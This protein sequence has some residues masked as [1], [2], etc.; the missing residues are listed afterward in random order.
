MHGL[1]GLHGYVGA[2]A[3]AAPHNAAISANT[4]SAIIGFHSRDLRRGQ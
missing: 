1:H 2:S 4:V 3:R